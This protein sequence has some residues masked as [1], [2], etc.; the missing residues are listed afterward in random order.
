ML[1]NN[2]QKRIFIYN[3]ITTLIRYNVNY[4]IIKNKRK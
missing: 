1:N 2:K 4:L 3:N